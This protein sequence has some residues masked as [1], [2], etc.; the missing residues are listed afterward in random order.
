MY[1]T[2][3]VDHV[4][5]DTTILIAMTRGDNAMECLDSRAF[6]KNQL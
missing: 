6:I 5:T 4:L 3:N 2:H 1:C